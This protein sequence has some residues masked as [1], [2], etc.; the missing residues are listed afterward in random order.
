MEKLTINEKINV[1]S[2]MR[3]KERRDNETVKLSYER[4]IRNK[5]TKYDG[6]C[7]W[8]YVMPC[9]NMNQLII[10]ANFQRSFK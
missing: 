10:N 2:N 4:S 6:L 9:N 7:L 3:T 8:F 5:A 1:R